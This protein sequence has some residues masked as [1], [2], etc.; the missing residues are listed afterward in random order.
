MGHFAVGERWKLFPQGLKPAIILAFFGTTEVV[1]FQ[2]LT[3]IRDFLERELQQE[4]LAL[5][6]KGVFD[7]LLRTMRRGIGT[8]LID[9][10]HLSDKR[11]VGF[12]DLVV[13]LFG[14]GHQ[15]LPTAFEH[16]SLDGIFV[17]KATG[18]ENSIEIGR[19]VACLVVLPFNL[20]A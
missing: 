12:E 6:V 3:L 9:S 14:H 10:L 13:A 17:V 19:R 5:I 11:T 15:L 2:N 16:C 8:G 7:F 18:T 20:D 4:P 1:P